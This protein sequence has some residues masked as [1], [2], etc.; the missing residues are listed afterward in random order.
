[1]FLDGN[2]GAPPTITDISAKP[3]EVA[4]HRRENVRFETLWHGFARF[5]REVMISEPSSQKPGDIP[6]D[7]FPIPAHPAQPPELTPSDPVNIPPPGQDVIFPAN[8]P[9]GIPRAPDVEP[10]PETP[11]VF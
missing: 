4:G 6:K 9:V 11:G 8:E 3:C 2:I 7:P 1:M 5:S 10:L